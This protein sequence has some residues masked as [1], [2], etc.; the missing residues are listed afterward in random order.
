MKRFTDVSLKNKIFFVNLAVI[1]IISSAIAFL[2]RWILVSSLISELEDRGTAIARTISER[3]SGFILDKNYPQLLSLIFDEAQ[4]TERKHLIAYIYIV[5]Q[6][7]NLLCHT[8]TRPFP[9]DL[10]LAN[11]VHP[12]QSRSIQL[13]SVMGREA[14]DIAT[15]IKEGIYRIGTVHVGL[16]KEHIDSLVSKLRI[17]FLGFI[18]LV[19]VIIFIM[20]HML[21]RYITRP[22]SKLTSLSDE[23]SRGNFDIKLD[24]GSVTD[25]WDPLKCPAYID[26]DLPCWHFDESAA[27]AK[28]LENL[29]D[30]FRACGNCV[31]Y[32]KRGR[33]EVAQLADSFHNMVWSIK[34]YR[35]RL[36]ESEEKYRSLFNSGPDPIFVIN[37]E[38]LEIIDANPRAVEVYGYTKDELIG[39]SF[40]EL[41]SDT[42]RQCTASFAEKDDAEGCVQF[43][44][45]LHQRKGD[46][47][48]HVNLHACRI[49]Y[50]GIPA[51][52]IAS[53]DISEMMEKDAQLIQ[54]SKLKSLGEMSAGMA[55][56]LN[57]PL[58][59]IK[60]GSDFLQW[61]SKKGSTCQ[62][63]I[64]TR[65]LQK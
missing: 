3:G 7:D 49:S 33:D 29:P 59:A 22:I 30:N 11:L 13:L 47:P 9:S 15:P 42:N 40:L 46:K 55:H 4:L 63:R 20:S 19:V 18:S 51:L 41:E 6:D 36:Y 50:K 17:T 44:K 65:L 25:G 5:D 37:S 14:Y 24:L 64:F 43:Q 48:F 39:M 54:A 38:S 58:N 27:S 16:N 21:S 57:Q 60:M 34:L 8:F 61:S 28:N 10:R 56:E 62:K 23:L 12:D 31:F 35:K 53:T 45:V 1:L 32:R 52:I 26:T 2:A